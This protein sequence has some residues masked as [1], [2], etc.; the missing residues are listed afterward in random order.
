MVRGCYES[1]K[2][3]HSFIPEYVPLPIDWG[4]YISRDDMHFY[5]AEYVEMDDVHPDAKAW[6]TVA[7]TLHR[8]SM[9][10]SPETKIRISRRR[11]HDQCPNVPMSN[12]WS[13]SWEGF[14]TQRMRSLLE[15]EEARCGKDVSFTGLKSV[16][17]ERVI[18]RY[19]RPL[20]SNGRLVQPCLLH[21]DL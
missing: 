21:G 16:L 11:F 1:E 19:L 14:W 15:I 9:G 2:A 6:A 10:K 4:S 5:L 20:E 12:S 7:S 8:R 3:L 18:P 13:S 17:L